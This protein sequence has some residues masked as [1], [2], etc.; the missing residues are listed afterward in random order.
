MKGV[1]SVEDMAR[2]AM[3]RHFERRLAASGGSQQAKQH[4]T[5]KIADCRKLDVSR[6]SRAEDPIHLPRISSGQPY[7]EDSW[8]MALPIGTVIEAGVDVYGMSGQQIVQTAAPDYFA[9]LWEHNE[10]RW[11]QRRIQH[12]I[13]CGA[14]PEELP[15]RVVVRVLGKGAMAPVEDR[16]WIFLINLVRMARKGNVMD[17][18]AE[19][20]A[21]ELVAPLKLPVK[22][23]RL[24][25]SRFVGGHE[26]VFDLRRPESHSYNKKTININLAFLQ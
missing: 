3:V 17:A 15:L 9:N 26:V 13:T 19:I 25:V 16:N 12:G 14:L 10:F 24:D 11:V 2:A 1:S 18:A 22:L 21:Y 4:W 6:P 7:A 20:N 23:N 5:R 8:P